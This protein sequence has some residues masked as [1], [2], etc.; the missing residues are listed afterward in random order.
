[1]SDLTVV[2]KALASPWAC[3][4]DLQCLVVAARHHGVHLSADQLTRDHDLTDGPLTRDDLAALGRHAGLAL[5]TIAMPSDLEALGDALPALVPLKNGNTLLLLRLDTSA[6]GK[7]ATLYDPLVG[8]ATPLVIETDRLAEA[9][10]GEIVLVKRADA[11][12]EGAHRPFGLGQLLRELVRER[13]LFRDIAIAAAIMSLFAL[14]PIMFWQLVVDRVLVYKNL[15]TL[16]V[17]I[18]GMGFIVLFET[19]FGYLRRSLILIATSRIDARLSTFT[20]NRLLNLAI[21]YFERT[22]TGMVTRDMNEIWRVRNFL[23]GQLFGTVLDSLVLV[24]VLPFMFWFSP[25]LATVVLGLGLLMVG[26]VLGFLPFIRRRTARAFAAEG[27][28][29]AYLVETVQGLRTVKSLALEPQRRRAWDRHVATAARLRRDAGQLVNFA[30][31][32][33]APFEKLMTTG[34]I[35]LAAYIAVTSDDPVMI[36]AL[37]AFGMLSQRVAQPLIQLAHLVQQFDEASRAV[38]TVARVV[39]QPPEEG[40]GSG[41]LRQPLQG[42]IEFSNVRFRYPGADSLALNDV[43]FRVASGG[44]FGIMG[45]SG[46]GKTTITRLLQGLHRQY[47]GLIRVD[48]SDLRAIDLD[49]LRRSTGVV[50]QESYLFAGTVRENIGAALPGA[51]FEQIVAAARLAGAEDFVERLPRGYDTPLVEGGMNL[52][53]GQRQRIAIARALIVNPSLLIFDE[54]TSALDPESEAVI[55]ANLRSI[56]EGRTVIMISH[57]LSSL[58]AADAILVLDGGRTIDT[59]K[60]QELLARCDL[61]RHLWRQQHFHMLVGAAQ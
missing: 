23:T 60:H 27:A 12:D 21:D 53:G 33:V 32:A 6:A 22:P 25:M 39:N 31:T 15:A 54:A 1:M 42:A 18:G 38:Q 58:V 17:L 36:G 41:G 48:G 13:R 47:D 8:E 59:G 2:S 50:L 16:H 11:A 51:G 10:T 44:I 52:S 30:Q 55:N 14:A 35:A 4:T 45:R 20:F 7:V 19:L 9:M 3:L 34:V 57:R 40:R 26:V 46:S 56:A 43:S 24:I 29:N 5:A 37:I 61:Y 49:H 28:Q